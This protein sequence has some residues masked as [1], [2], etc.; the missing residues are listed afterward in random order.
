MVSIFVGNFNGSIDIRFGC[1]RKIFSIS[2][3]PTALLVGARKR[4]VDT[5]FPKVF[6]VTLYI[7]VKLILGAK[8]P[9]SFILLAEVT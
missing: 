2:T 5:L 6:W 4:W 8:M 7:V 3:P 9:S 1:K